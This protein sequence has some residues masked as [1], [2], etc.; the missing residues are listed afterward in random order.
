MLTYLEVPAATLVGWI[1]FGESPAATSLA[2]GALI[3]AGAVIA[4]RS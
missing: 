1:A 2:G 4:A 3:L